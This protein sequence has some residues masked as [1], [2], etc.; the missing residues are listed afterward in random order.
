[1]NLDWSRCWVTLGKHWDDD[2]GTEALV[3]VDLVHDLLGDFGRDGVV[4]VGVI[5]LKP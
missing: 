3:R 5:V 1:M 4:T 2:V